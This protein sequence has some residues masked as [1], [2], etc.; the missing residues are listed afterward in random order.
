V[1]DR[2]G[3]PGEHRFRIAVWDVDR[4]LPEL[5]D[6]LDRLNAAQTRFQFTVANLSA[7]LDAFKVEGGVR[8]LWKERIA[9]RLQGCAGELGANQLLCLTHYPLNSDSGKK[10]YTWWPKDMKSVVIFSYAGMPLDPESRDTARALTNAT[11]RAI[12]ATQRGLALHRGTHKDCP[13]YDN[14]EAAMPIITGRQSF[15]E[16]CCAKFDD[17]GYLA[18]LDALLRVFDTAADEPELPSKPRRAT[19]KRRKK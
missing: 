16:D 15:D 6:I 8:Y 19:R 3:A 5:E 7:P 17:A 10:V 14:R 1:A 13:M 11:V 4:A 18:A 12:A 2:S 9:R